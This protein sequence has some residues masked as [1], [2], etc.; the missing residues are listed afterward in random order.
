MKLMQRLGLG[1]IVLVLS[2]GIDPARAMSEAEWLAYLG[3]YVTP[4]GRVIDTA[5]EGISHS[6]GQGYGMLL[7]LA[8]DDQDTFRRLWDWTRSE[9]QVRDDALF[10]W[11]WDPAVH[12]G[13]VTD[14]NNATDGDLLIAWALLCAG[15]QWLEP[16]YIKAADAILR[17][18]K[19]K[20]VVETSY[21]PVLLP[22]AKGFVREGSVVV[23]PSY[24][25]F[26]ALESFAAH[27]GDETWSKLI[28]SGVELLK[29]GRFG[30]WRLPPDWLEVGTGL[31]LPK[32]FAPVFGY[33]AIKI[34]LYLTWSD[35]PE[36][37]ALLEPFRT[38][39]AS[40]DGQ[41]LPPA[42]VDLQDG[43]EGEQRL[44]NGTRAIMSLVRFGDS[45]PLSAGAMM[46]QLQPT[47]DYYSSNSPPSQQDCARKGGE[48]GGVEKGEKEP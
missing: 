7:A 33:N 5:N 8:F 41:A 17:D 2:S 45:S 14:P 27:D 13:Q 31:T 24:W 23:N 19:A 36:A 20:M 44:S 29:I 4:Y 11:K 43:K 26:P 39:W 28:R 16:E 40:F 22:G 35:L 25:V 48:E 15:Q 3:T 6:E 37:G 1:L 9:L 21:G 30:E 47:D 32:G 38:F 34:P 46:P 18:V 12:G 42:T 10:A